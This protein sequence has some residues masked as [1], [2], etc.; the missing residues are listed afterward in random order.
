MRRRAR[1]PS[2]RA[3]LFG[4]V[5]LAVA[6]LLRVGR[7]FEGMVR[8]SSLAASLRPPRALGCAVDDATFLNEAAKVAGAPSHGG[9]APTCGRIAALA[10]YWVDA[11][12][13]AGA[14][15]L[16]SARI[17]DAT[18]DNHRAAARARN[19]RYVRG[20]RGHP[21]C[22]KM[23]FVQE[24]LATLQ[25]GEWLLFLDADAAL[26]ACRR[27]AWETFAS[28]ACQLRA[29]YAASGHRLFDPTS[30][31]A[32]SKFGVFLVRNDVW[33]ALKTGRGNAAAA[34]RIVHGPERLGP[35]TTCAASR[36]RS[37]RGRCCAR[38]RRSQKTPRP[39]SSRP[40]PIVATTRASRAS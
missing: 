35:A 12:R 3:L 1:R 40:R 23:R 30:L 25:E 15:P 11:P 19:V 7:E 36:A 20:T 4:G 34:T 9:A 38:R 37:R 16:F 8:S 21:R 6:L 39:P 5:A 32:G 13:V 29:D 31:L 17:V 2:P 18:A 33:A 22:G 26:S 28:A 24:T 10:T 14:A 27:D